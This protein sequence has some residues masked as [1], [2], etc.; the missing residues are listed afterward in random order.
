ML[1]NIL[2]KPVPFLLKILSAVRSAAAAFVRFFKRRITSWPKLGLLVFVLLFVLYYPLGAFMTDSIDTDTAYEAP[3][4]ENQSATVSAAAYLIKRE[5]NDKIWTPNLPFF[6]P[7]SVLDNMPAFQKGLMSGIT[8]AMT[9]LS[10]RV[11]IKDDCP[12]VKSAE[13]LNYPP[14]I[15]MFSPQS[16]LLPVPSSNSQYRR[17]RK[18]LLKY[19]EALSRGE[20]IFIK[21]PQDLDYILTKVRTDLL[22]SAA[23]LEK[24]IR[25][26][27]T[28]LID[29]K[30]DEIFYHQQ[31]K[32]YGYYILLKALSADY[33]D[34]ILARDLYQPWTKLLKALED[35]S[36]LSPLIVR[37]G[38]LDSSF[39]PNHLA[40]I[41]L[42][43]DRAV[44]RLTGLTQNLSVL[45]Q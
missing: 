24:H 27:S 2:T 13:L 32:L 16:K 19:N 30:A 42:Y 1:K 22:K 10:K 29:N 18:H 23:G 7:A 33:K 40:V 8:T 5:I 41:G 17:A 4:V 35:A 20:T 38:R 34:I 43:T 44:I 45:P 14:T 9:A 15:W 3:A 36:R 6:F 37:N 28:A 31:G 12:L 21:R 39:A 25:E 11:P 26:N